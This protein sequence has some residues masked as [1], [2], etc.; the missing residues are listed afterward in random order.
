MDGLDLR[1]LNVAAVPL[2]VDID[3]RF[4]DWLVQRLAR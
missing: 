3:S 4:M 1:E 2:M